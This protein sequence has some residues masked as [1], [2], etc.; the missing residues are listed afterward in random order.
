MNGYAAG[1]NGVLLKTTD[2][3]IE[4]RQIETG[5][6]WWIQAL[7]FPTEMIGYAAGLNGTILKTTDAG[8]TWT[9]QNS[10]T[11]GRLRDIQF[12]DADIGWV[13][14]NHGTVLATTDGGAVWNATF[15][16]YE[17]DFLGVH[18]IDSKNIW[19]AAS[20]I[21]GP[22]GIVARTTDGGETWAD[23]GMPGRLPIRSICFADDQNG[24]FIGDG[25]TI[26]HASWSYASYRQPE[27]S[28]RL[29]V[30]S[31]V[32]LIQNYPNPFNASTNI[33]FYL[34][35]PGH[36]KL[37]VYNANGQRVM[38][39]ADGYRASGDHLIQMDS[40]GLTSGIYYLRLEV[41]GEVLIKKCTVLK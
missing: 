29:T 11:A 3:G 41:A 17:L 39:L 27:A 8:E 26:L 34:E 9:P 6:F 4:W 38:M 21:F 32:G 35:N 12:L 23:M 40:N 33:R 15:I 22:Y 1:W 14:G 31:G 18:F 28:A 30:P 13:V 37:S 36:V 16:S 10:G 2:G 20:Y 19:I 24:W 7:S 5:T 25:G